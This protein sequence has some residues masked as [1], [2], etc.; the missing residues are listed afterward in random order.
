MPDPDLSKIE[1]GRA[2]SLRNVTEVFVIRAESCQPLVQIGNQVFA[3]SYQDT[4][5]TSL[6]FSQ[7]DRPPGD[8]DPVFGRAVKKRLSFLAATR[9]K[10]LLKRVFLKERQSGVETEKDTETKC[11]TAGAARS[12]DSSAAAASLDTQGCVTDSGSV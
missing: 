7:A 8:H 1:Q 2:D 5:G 11:E 10:L 6:F 9:K 3:G 4:L 12:S